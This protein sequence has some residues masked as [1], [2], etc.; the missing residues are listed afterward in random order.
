MTAWQQE[1][2]GTEDMYGKSPY[3]YINL[4]IQRNHNINWHI[5]EKVIDI[6]GGSRISQ[7]EHQPIIWQNFVKNCMKRKKFD[8]QGRC[9][10]LALLDPPLNLQKKGDYLNYTLYQKYHR[11]TES[12]KCV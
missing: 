4:C 5:S 7:G 12:Q 1:W 9:T 3:L 2:F 10:S 6:H 11:V 8:Q